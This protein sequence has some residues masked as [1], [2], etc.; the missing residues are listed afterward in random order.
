MMDFE[1]ICPFI[2]GF[3]VPCLLAMPVFIY[4]NHKKLEVL[5]AF[6]DEQGF[7]YAEDDLFP[8]E[9]TWKS[10]TFGSR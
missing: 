3:G 7:Q 4:L 2:T 8:M 9:G 10:P 5:E 1:V 6:V